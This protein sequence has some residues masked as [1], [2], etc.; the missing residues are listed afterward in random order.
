MS[1]REKQELLELW[2]L[3]EIENEHKHYS[4][5]LETAKAKFWE[6]DD[7]EEM[8]NLTRE[9]MWAREQIRQTDKKYQAVMAKNS[10]HSLF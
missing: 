1:Q 3:R 9:I 10:K 6:S 5:M 8:E 2:E 4:E 7:M